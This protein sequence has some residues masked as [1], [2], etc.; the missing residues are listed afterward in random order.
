LAVV[1]FA[2]VRGGFSTA[3]PVAA[4]LAVNSLPAVDFAAALRAVDLRAL[5]ALPADAIPD[6]VFPVVTAFLP[7]DSEF[8]P[9]AFFFGV[10]LTLS[11]DVALAAVL[12]LDLSLRRLLVVVCLAEPASGP[13]P[14]AALARVAM[15]SPK[16]K[17]GA[18]RNAAHSR[19]WQEYGTYARPTNMPHDM[20]GSGRSA[21]PLSQPRPHSSCRRSIPT[22]PAFNPALSGIRPR[23]ECRKFSIR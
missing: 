18:R 13:I 1:A 6:A 19:G 10:A 23:R 21:P 3:R 14:R 22:L 4:S 20:G 2:V 12:T 17:T 5:E 15:A 9:P 16:C 8:A 11:A 7:A